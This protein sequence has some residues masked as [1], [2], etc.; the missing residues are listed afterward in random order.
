MSSCCVCVFV[1]TS[2]F[3]EAN[4]ALDMFAVFAI[5]RP[6]S[7]T[8]LRRYQ[9]LG[10]HGTVSGT[11]EGYSTASRSEKFSYIESGSKR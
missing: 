9:V 10:G 1:Y 6:R 5:L 4:L 2:V 7:S 11:P 8:L 3:A